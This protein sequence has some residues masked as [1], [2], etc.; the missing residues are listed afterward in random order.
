M[1]IPSLLWVYY[2]SVTFIYFPYCFVS[3]LFLIEF[4]KPFN[5]MY[6]DLLEASFEIQGKKDTAYLLS[7]SYKYMTNL[8][9]YVFCYKFKVAFY[10]ISH[11]L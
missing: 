3:V 9:T 2:V 7:N 1:L 10:Y 4:K 8:E 5:K 6:T 11:L